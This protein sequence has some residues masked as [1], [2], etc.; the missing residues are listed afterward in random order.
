VRTVNIRARDLALPPGIHFERASPAS[1]S[2][3]LA[4]GR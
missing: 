1:V 3:R 4:P 2:V